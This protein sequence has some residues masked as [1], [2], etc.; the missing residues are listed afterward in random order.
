MCFK[1]YPAKFFESF[2]AELSVRTDS[3]NIIN[4]VSRK[5]VIPVVCVII[6]NGMQSN[7]TISIKV[8]LMA[9]LDNH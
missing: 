1:I 2:N 4:A 9:I 3:F 8:Y 6:G 7:T 5:C